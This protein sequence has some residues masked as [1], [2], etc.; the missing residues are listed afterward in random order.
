MITPEFNKLTGVFNARSVQANLINKTEFDSR[1]SN[2]NRKINKNKSDH[3]LLQNE[4]NQ[5]ET[6]DPRYFFG[7]SLF[8]ED[9]TQNYFV[10]QSLNKYFKLITNTLSILSWQSKGLSTENIYHPTTSLSPSI[11][12]VR[13]KIRVK[14]TGSCLKQ[15]NRLTYTYGKALNIYMVYKLGGSSSNNNDPELNCLFG[16]VTLTKMQTL[17][18]NNILVMELDLIE[19]QVFHFQMVDLVKLY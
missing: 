18:N 17:I 11:I 12:Y 1:L 16:T 13:N 5:L 4:L 3:L 10:F 6:F 7:K 2:L 8:E 15:S 19:D 9:G 14:F